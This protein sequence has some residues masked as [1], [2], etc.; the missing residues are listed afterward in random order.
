MCCLFTTSLDKVLQERD[1]SLKGL[2]GLQT[3]IK[4]KR[5]WESRKLGT[6]GSEEVTAF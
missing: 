5:E 3:G 4:A 2:T 6:I 1:W